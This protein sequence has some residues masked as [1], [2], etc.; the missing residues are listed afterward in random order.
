MIN[1]I[2][3]L[4]LYFA[5]LVAIVSMFLSLYSSEIAGLM[6]CNLCWYQRICMFPLALILGVATYRGEGRVGAYAYPLAVL[7]LCF[8][9]YQYIEQMLPGF[10]PIDLCGSGPSCSDT[11]FMWLGF[12]TY[13]FLSIIAFALIIAG[14]MIYKKPQYS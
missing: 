11:S 6:V 9:S 5:W 4:G 14:L 1:L 3:T 2:R 12:I 10:M 7:G 13:P 8:A